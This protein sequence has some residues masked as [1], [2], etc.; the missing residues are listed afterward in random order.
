[1]P[2]PGEPGSLLVFNFGQ[3]GS[4]PLKVLLT[5][6]RLLDA[7]IHPSAVMLETLPI[8][9]V[10]D[11]PAER[12]FR[13]AEARL[14]AG[15][16]R[17]LAPYSA[18]RSTLSRHWLEAR[19]APW[20]AHRVVL[21]SHWLPRWLKWGDRIDPQWE[22]MRPDGFVP[23]PNQFATSEFR[24]IATAH[25]RD[26][27]AGSFAGYAFGESSVRALRDLVDRCRRE[28][29]DLIWVE[30]PVS[31]MFRGWFTPGVWDGGDERLRLLA[32]D[33]GVEFAPPIEGL[34]EAHFIDGHHLL[35]ESAVIYS[36]RLA[37][38]YLGPWLAR[39]RGTTP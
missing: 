16:L 23:Y 9:L 26:E 2:F 20:S 11:G 32:A 37:E 27:H 5:L 17:R 19:I 8:W 4:P 14:S 39:S 1:M 29:I 25:A 31:P 6:E 21:M 18:D 22:G 33:L 35:S 15:D 12:I 13:D 24:A 7:G 28:R 34:D 10:A 3:S 30:P 36:R 38:Q